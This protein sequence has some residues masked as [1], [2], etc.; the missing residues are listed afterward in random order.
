MARLVEAR[1]GLD[2]QAGEAFLARLVLLLGNE[3]GDLEILLHLVSAAQSS[4]PVR[5][6]DVAAIDVDA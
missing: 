1:D 3:V 4:D 2:A 6:E 5:G